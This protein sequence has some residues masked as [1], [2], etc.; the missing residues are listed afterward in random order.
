MNPTAGNPFAPPKADLN[1][2]PANTPADQVGLASR[3]QRFAASFVDGIVVWVGIAPAYLGT[4]LVAAAQTGKSMKNPLF[5]Y[6]QTGKWGAVAALLT[7][8][9][10]VLQWTLIVRRGQTIGKMA[11]GTRI[12]MKDGSRAGFA[13][14]LALR[15]W[16][17]WVLNQITGVITAF[18]AV[19]LIDILLIFRGD[20]RC[21][22]DLLA[23]TKVVRVP[24]KMKAQ[25]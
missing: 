21:G 19:G 18:A 9:L 1:V 25:L 7:I 15:T 4:S 24:L 16:P 13:Q 2:L 10:T 17:V 14:A 22:H 3:W 12:V 23:G 6:T 8:V 11:A 5:L 20:K